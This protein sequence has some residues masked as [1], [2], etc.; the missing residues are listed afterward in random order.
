MEKA[1]AAGLWKGE[2]NADIRAAFD[3]ASA[4][5]GFVRVG[6]FMREEFARGLMRAGMEEDRARESAKKI[7]E[8][9]HDVR[10]RAR[11]DD[12]A[13]MTVIG[14]SE[15]VKMVPEGQAMPRLS[16]PVR[17]MASVPTSRFFPLVSAARI[18]CANTIASRIPAPKAT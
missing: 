11:V 17:F 10:H 14:D 8:V 1:K 15:G 7:V 3:A 18:G 13:S 12:R 5:A 9:T 2:A 16:G 4:K 6:R